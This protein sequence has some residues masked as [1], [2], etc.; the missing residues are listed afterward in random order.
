MYFQL[1]PFFT[2]GSEVTLV[3]DCKLIKGSSENVKQRHG[4]K[5]INFIT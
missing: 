1:F 3:T 5:L 4:E 2:T